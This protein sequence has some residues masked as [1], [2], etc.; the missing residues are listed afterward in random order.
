MKPYLQTDP[1]LLLI[2]IYINSAVNYI[3]ELGAPLKIPP[4]VWKTIQKQFKLKKTLFDLAQQFKCLELERRLQGM[5]DLGDED[6]PMPRVEY[7][8]ESE[9]FEDVYRFM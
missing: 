6:E 5:D 3:W 8:K 4:Q 1:K 2:S 9:L 7:A